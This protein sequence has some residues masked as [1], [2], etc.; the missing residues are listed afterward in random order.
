MTSVYEN[1]PFFENEKFEF[2]FVKKSDAPDLLEVYS[3]KNALPFFNSDN[4]HGDN[5]YYPTIQRMEQAISFWLESYK[6]KWFVRFSIID[7]ENGKAVGTVELFH[8]ASTDKFNDAGVLRI[9]VKSSYENRDALFSV[10]SAIVPPAYELFECSQI[11]TKIPIYAIERIAAASEF[12]FTKSEFLLVGTNDGYA[13]NG[14]WS[15]NI[16]G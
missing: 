5:F 16:N 1:C 4:C 8:R 7:K 12:G 10:F 2:R 11:I 6:N 3:D 9:D 14:Y 13:Y 15:K